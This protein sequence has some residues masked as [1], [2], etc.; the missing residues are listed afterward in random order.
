MTEDIIPTRGSLDRA[1]DI[2][3]L[4]D[5]TPTDRDTIAEGFD[6][7]AETVNDAIRTGLRLG[8][9]EETS[10][11]VRATNPGLDVARA[12][13]GGDRRATAMQQIFAEHPIYTEIFRTA[14]QNVNDG[15]IVAT[16]VDRAIRV[17]GQ[18]LGKESRAAAVT[19]FL[20]TLEMAGIGEYKQSYK[21]NPERVEIDNEDQLAELR[22]RIQDERAAT[23]DPEEDLS[24]PL[25]ESDSPDSNT[26]SEVTDDGVDTSPPTEGTSQT[27]TTSAIPNPPADRAIRSQAHEANFDISLSLDGTEDPQRIERLVAAVSR[28]LASDLDTS[29][30]DTTAGVSSE[31]LATDAGTQS[32]SSVNSQDSGSETNPTAVPSHTQTKSDSDESN[33]ESETEPSTNDNDPTPTTKPTVDQAEKPS[34]EDDTGAQPKEADESESSPEG[35]DRFS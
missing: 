31:E 35:L 10:E 6:N 11:G 26:S 20:K 12:T 33:D 18:D 29:A 28:G 13:E 3:L 2:C 34:A 7:T 9:L 19:T 5:R 22:A 16:D 1:I 23:K 15:Q 21:Q 25:A 17:R 32:P 8:L 27:A 14:A 4:I 24:E 30:G